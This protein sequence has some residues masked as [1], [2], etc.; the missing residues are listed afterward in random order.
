MEGTA[1]EGPYELLYLADDHYEEP[2]QFVPQSVTEH[3]ICP[4]PTK[5]QLEL[6]PDIQ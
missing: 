1:A 3:P 2:D 6:P 5:A 4:I